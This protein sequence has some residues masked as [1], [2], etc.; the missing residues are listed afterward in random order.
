[1][2]RGNQRAVGVQLYRAGIIDRAEENSSVANVIFRLDR[3]DS[4]DNRLTVDGAC[5][6]EKFEVRVAFH[7]RK[8]GFHST[9]AR[10]NKPSGRKTNETA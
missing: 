3:W 2:I 6:L 4:G 1:M 8:A 9:D 5:L 7:T 10:M